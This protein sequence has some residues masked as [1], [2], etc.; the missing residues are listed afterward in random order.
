MMFAIC[1]TFVLSVPIDVRAE[2]EV[3]ENTE[4]NIKG[5]VIDTKTQRPLS[6]ASVLVIGTVITTTTDA[7]VIIR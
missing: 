5:S 4:A 6:H 3:K 2:N 1:A 7:E